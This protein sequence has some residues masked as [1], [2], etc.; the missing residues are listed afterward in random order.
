MRMKCFQLISNEEEHSTSTSTRRYLN[1]ADLNNFASKRS[2]I[3][4]KTAAC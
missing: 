1:L 2:K 4:K 3:A